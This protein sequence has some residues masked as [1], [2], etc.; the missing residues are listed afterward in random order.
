L[1]PSFFL[2][3]CFIDFGIFFSGELL[4]FIFFGGSLGEGDKSLSE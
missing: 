4:G 3:V 2:T 1:S